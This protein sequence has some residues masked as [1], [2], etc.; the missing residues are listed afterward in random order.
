MRDYNRHV[1]WK[2]AAPNRSI[3][4]LITVALCA[5]LLATG[6]FGGSVSIALH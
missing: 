3:G 2:P 5:L 6:W 1:E 4:L